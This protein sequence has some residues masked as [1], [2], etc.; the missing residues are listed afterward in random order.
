MVPFPSHE[1]E[2]FNG[3][4]LAIIRAEPGLAGTI[5]LKAKSDP[6][7]EVGLVLQVVEVSDR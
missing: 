3:L 1:R 5:T 6:L 2:A 7:K 4:C